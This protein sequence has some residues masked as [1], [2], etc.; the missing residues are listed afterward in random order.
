MKLSVLV[1]LV[2]YY[3]RLYAMSCSDQAT[4]RQ[5]VVCHGPYMASGTPIIAQHVTDNHLWNY[6]KIITYFYC[7]QFC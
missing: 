1:I 2:E 4:T 3:H 6:A 7:S 5:L